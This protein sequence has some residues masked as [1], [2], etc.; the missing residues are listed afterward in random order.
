MSLKRDL[1]VSQKGPIICLAKEPYT[2][3]KDAQYLRQKSPLCLCQQI[4]GAFVQELYIS[5]KSDLYVSQKG[6][7]CLSKETYMSLKRALYLLERRPKSTS[8][9]ISISISADARCFGPKSHISLAKETYMSLKRD[10]YLRQKSLYIYVKRDPCIYMGWLRLVGSLKLYVSLEN[11]GL[12]CR[13]LLQKRPIILRS[14]LIVATPYQ[15]MHRALVKRAIYLSQKSHIS[16]AK[17]P[18]IYATRHSVRMSKSHISLL[19]KEPYISRKRALHLCHKTL[20]T[21]VK[22]VPYIYVKRTLNPYIHINK[23]TVF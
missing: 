6:P 10:L 20:C 2:Y 19:Y 16:L 22:I 4:D 17:E 18:Y 23:Y 8:K 11:I 12:F 9:E 14:L 3:S 1:Y 21:H 15:E 7:I 5:R 13:A